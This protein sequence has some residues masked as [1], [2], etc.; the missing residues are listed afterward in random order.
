MSIRTLATLV[1]L[2][3]LVLGACQRQAAAPSAAGGAP[4]AVRYVDHVAAGALPAPGATPE[5]PHRGDA[6]VARN[7][8]LLFTSM[9]CD[10][11]HGGD[12][13]GWVGPNL[14]D[15]RWRYGGSDAEIFASIY[16]GRPKGMPAFGGTLGPEG[17]WTLVTY[18]QSLPVP[19]DEAT[20][21]WEP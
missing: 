5:N 8:A 14:G 7:G 10:G 6:A 15:G 11:C 4:P 9:N 16:Y 12:A 2:T 3:L 1:P 20:E 19:K 18:L 17:V 13:A 21:S